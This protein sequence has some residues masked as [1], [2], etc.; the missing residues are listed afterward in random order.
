MA[1]LTDAGF[2]KVVGIGA[3]PRRAVR[4]LVFAQLDR[5]QVNGLEEIAERLLGKLNADC[6]PGCARRAGLMQAQAGFIG[7]PGSA[8]GSWSP[9]GARGTSAP[10]SPSALF[11]GESCPDPAGACA[12]RCSSSAMAPSSSAARVCAHRVALSSCRTLRDLR[13]LPGDKHGPPVQ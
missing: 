12:V 11:G 3:Q 8:G 1:T 9:A 4:E 10:S 2:A 6:V 7:S 13:P 5:E